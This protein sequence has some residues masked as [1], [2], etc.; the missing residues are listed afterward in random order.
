MSVIIATAYMEEAEQCDWLVAMNGGRILATGSPAQFKARTQSTS[1]E[2]SFV[3]LLP[4]GPSES[5]KAFTASSRGFSGR[6]AV[7]VARHLT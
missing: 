5:R 1:L 2:A 3:S 6:D 4:K 7:I